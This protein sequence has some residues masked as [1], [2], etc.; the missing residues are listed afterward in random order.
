MRSLVPTPMHG[1]GD[2]VTEHGGGMTIPPDPTLEPDGDDLLPA[3]LV[4]SDDNPLAR[5][6]PDGE[7]A[8]DLLHDGKGVTERL[9]EPEDD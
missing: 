2:G 1:G 5:G 8:G 3:D 7:T 4:P 9:H 6:L